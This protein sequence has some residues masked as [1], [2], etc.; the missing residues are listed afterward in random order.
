LQIYQ[1][2]LI[3]H[4]SLKEP[5][6]GLKVW[7]SRTLVSRKKGEVLFHSEKESEKNIVNKVNKVGF[8]AK[9]VEE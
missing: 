6:K 3:D 4:L 1:D 7:R 2:F 5:R 9:V 8:K